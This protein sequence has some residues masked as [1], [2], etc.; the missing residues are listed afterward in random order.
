MIVLLQLMCSSPVS[1]GKDFALAL[2]SPLASTALATTRTHGQRRHLQQQVLQQQQQCQHPKQHNRH[3]QQQV[4]PL[5]P[6]KLLHSQLASVHKC[7]G[8]IAGCQLQAQQTLLRQPQQ[9]HSAVQHN[10]SSSSRHACRH[11][12]SSSSHHGDLPCKRP[13]CLLPL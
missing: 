8:R 3:L 10:S 7:S 2:F 11:N 12:S 1:P 5:Q 9:L 6:A 4:L 13:K